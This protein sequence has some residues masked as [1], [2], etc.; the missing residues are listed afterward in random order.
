MDK[1]AQ[2]DVP[3]HDLI[4]HRWSPRA[5]DPDA[6]LPDRALRAL[7][8]AARWAASYGNTQPARYLV[9]R[10]PDASFTR[11]LGTLSENNQSWAHR[12]SALL[13]AVAVTRNAKGEVPFAEYGVGLATQNLV[14]QAVAEGL[15]AHQMA[16]FDPE[17]VRR[18]F[19]LPDEARPVVAIAVGTP[20]GAEVLGD[21]RR[22]ERERAARER[23][24]LVELAFTDRWGTPAVP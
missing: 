9:G 23:L 22:I 1:L 12:A 14:L 13:V 11:L 20:T 17:A 15:A 6:V 19:A 10:R 21:P 16:G 24:P 5:F 2:T 8:E 3:V 7:L 4:A 18:E